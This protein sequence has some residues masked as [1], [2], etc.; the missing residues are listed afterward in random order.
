MDEKSCVHTVCFWCP[1]LHFSQPTAPSCMAQLS[2]APLQWH[3]TP[4]LPSRHLSASASASTSTSSVNRCRAQ[5]KRK[6]KKKKSVTESLVFYP[7]FIGGFLVAD[8]SGPRV[9]YPFT[10]P[11]PLFCSALCSLPLCSALP[12][13]TPPFIPRHFATQPYPTLQIA[14]FTN[15]CRELVHWTWQDRG[16][17]RAYMLL[18]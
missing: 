13:S 7:Q 17:A 4:F 1:E 9:A 16:T 5:K 10:A 3:H 11:H 14:G 8:P 15:S 12:L 2:L 18:H 6:E